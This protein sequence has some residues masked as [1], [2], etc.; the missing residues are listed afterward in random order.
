MSIYFEESGHILATCPG[1][2]NHQLLA[3]LIIWN[4]ISSMLPLLISV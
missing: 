4:I 3:F 2:Y 1:I